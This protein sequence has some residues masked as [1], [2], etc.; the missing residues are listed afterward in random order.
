MERDVGKLGYRGFVGIANLQGSL[1]RGV[2][3]RE[4]FIAAPSGE[5]RDE[6]MIAPTRMLVKKVPAPVPGRQAAGMRKVDCSFFAYRPF[7][8]GLDT[9]TILLVSR[10]PTLE[11]HLQMVGARGFEPPTF[12]SQSRKH[13]NEI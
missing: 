9:G 2:I 7:L 6:T 4:F 3:A 5:T 8:H 13:N 11:L 10:S 12:C 1:K